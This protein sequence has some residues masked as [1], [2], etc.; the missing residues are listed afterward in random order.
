MFFLWYTSVTG[1]AYIVLAAMPS[2]DHE[3]LKYLLRMHSYAS[4]Y[5]WNLSGLAVICRRGDFPIR[6]H[7]KSIITVHWLTAILLAPLGTYYQPLAIAALVAYGFV[8]YM[9]LFSE[10]SRPILEDE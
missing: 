7:S 4:L 2:Y 1:I 5:G 10:G 3:G 6:L 8:L 9:I